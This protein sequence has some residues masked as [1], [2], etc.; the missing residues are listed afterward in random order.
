M[1]SALITVSL[2]FYFDLLVGN[3]WLAHVM[4]EGKFAILQ[5]IF[6]LLL[7]CR[8]V[9]VVCDNEWES[10]LL[11]VLDHRSDLFNTYRVG[12]LKGF[13]END[14]DFIEFIVV[15]IQLDILEKEV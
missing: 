13:E 9:F 15:F 6:C 1:V 3:G 4:K 2:W 7:D 8:L 5:F 12:D 10:A 11:L 14:F